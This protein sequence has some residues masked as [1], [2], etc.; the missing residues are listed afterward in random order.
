MCK[1]IVPF[2]VTLFGGWFRNLV[3]YNVSLSSPCQWYVCV[4][5]G[6]LMGWWWLKQIHEQIKAYISNI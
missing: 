1:K 6:G 2:F 4:W 5:V 3:I